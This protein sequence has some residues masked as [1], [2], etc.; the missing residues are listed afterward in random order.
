MAKHGE[1]SDREAGE[2]D[3]AMRQRLSPLTP[4]YAH[5]VLS[6]KCERSIIDGARG[7]DVRGGR[8]LFLMFF[9]PPTHEFL[10]YRGKKRSV[11]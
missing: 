7:S 3:S 1:Q 10:M 5:A 4:P 8:S 2:E 6:F 11:K 9:F